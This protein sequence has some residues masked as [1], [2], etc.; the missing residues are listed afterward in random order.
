[1]AGFLFNG[2]SL[3]LLLPASDA[4]LESRAPCG[5]LRQDWNPAPTTVVTR[6]RTFLFATGVTA[7]ILLPLRG[8][9]CSQPPKLP[10]R[11]LDRR[12]ILD[13]ISLSQ[14]G[15]GRAT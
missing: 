2:L 4:G 15:C 11:M 8:M 14:R 9:T 12:Q 3:R 7:D 5:N 10:G 6:P 13:G 1:M